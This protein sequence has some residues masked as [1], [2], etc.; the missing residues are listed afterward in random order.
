MLCR[1]I[2]SRRIRSNLLSPCPSGVMLMQDQ[3]KMHASLSPKVA[4]RVGRRSA[5]SDTLIAAKGLGVIAP[6]RI[7]KAQLPAPFSISS[8]TIRARQA[9]R[10][11]S[12]LLPFACAQPAL[13]GL[14]AYFNTDRPSSHPAGCRLPSSVPK[15]PGPAA[16]YNRGTGCRRDRSDCAAGCRP[17]F[18]S[19]AHP[20]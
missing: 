1:A 3:D 19:R 5:A 14:R 18:H 11:L 12:C 9:S 13:T 8:R 2:P 7:K 10:K 17:R 20:S 16:A 4:T 6:A 15:S